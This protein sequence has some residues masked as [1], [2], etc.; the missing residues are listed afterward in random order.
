[1]NPQQANTEPIESSSFKLNKSDCDA[2]L[3]SYNKENFKLRLE[4]VVMECKT[5]K[6]SLQKKREKMKEKYEGKAGRKYAIAYYKI[7]DK[8]L[9]VTDFFRAVL[10]DPEFYVRN[11]ATK[12]KTLAIV[13][14]EFALS[15]IWKSKGKKTTDEGM[16]KRCIEVLNCF[17]REVGDLTSQT[18]K[19]YFKNKVTK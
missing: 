11:M 9:E 8:S 16:Y 14:D 15:E 10:V 6:K 7:G 4:T 2:V 1:M 3:I 19:E 13:V 17:W 18:S 12:H 5:S